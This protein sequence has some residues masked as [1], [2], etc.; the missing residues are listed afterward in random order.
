MLRQS[1]Q[2][3]NGFACRSQSSEQRN[4]STARRR[5]GRFNWHKSLPGFEDLEKIV[6]LHGRK[7][8]VVVPGV[9]I[10]RRYDGSLN[11]Y[12]QCYEIS[13]NGIHFERPHLNLVAFPGSHEK[14]N[15]VH[16]RPSFLTLMTPIH[17]IDSK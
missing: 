6:R 15:L 4:I 17:R 1:A 5:S 9:N 2:H 3:A 7:G 13:K 11:V 12:A 10:R 14:T 8:V 16:Y